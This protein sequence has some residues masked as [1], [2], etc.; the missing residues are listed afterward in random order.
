MN[1][2]RVDDVSIEIILRRLVAMLASAVG[3]VLSF[4]ALALAYYAIL[5]PLAFLFRL[6]GRDALGLKKRGRETYWTPLRTPDDE[7]AYERLF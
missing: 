1:D 2:P 3:A 6:I 5:T 4:A 7:A